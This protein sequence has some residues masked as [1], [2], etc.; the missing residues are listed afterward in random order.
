[1]GWFWSMQSFRDPENGASAIFN[2]MISKVSLEEE[3]YSK[4]GKGN[5][6]VKAY[7]LLN[8]LDTDKAYSYAHVLFMKTTH[9]AVPKYKGHLEIQ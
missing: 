6:M 7:L 2:S 4:Q 9:M 5:K 8:H 1:M 3:T